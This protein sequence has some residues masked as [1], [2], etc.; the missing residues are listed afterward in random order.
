MNLINELSV[1]LF[2]D[3]NINTKNI[4]YSYLIAKDK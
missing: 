4:K 3:T 1:G 2:I